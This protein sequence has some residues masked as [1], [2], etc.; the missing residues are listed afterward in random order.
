[1]PTRTL[2]GSSSL[3]FRPGFALSGRT[4][5]WLGL[6]KTLPDE[7]EVSLFCMMIEGVD[8]WGVERV[9]GSRNGTVT[10]EEGADVPA[11]L[12]DLDRRDGTR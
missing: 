11:G 2:S 9:E 5:S 3:T 7:E 1:M 4:H 8:C 12:D 6:A 10:D